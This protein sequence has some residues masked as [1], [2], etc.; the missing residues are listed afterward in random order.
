MKVKYSRSAPSDV[1]DQFTSLPVTVNRHHWCLTQENFTKYEDIS[2][3][4]CIHKHTMIGIRRNRE[5]SNI[6]TESN[7]SSCVQLWHG[8]V[9]DSSVRELWSRR[10]SVHF[11]SGS[12][13]L[14]VLC[15]SGRHPILLVKLPQ[16]IDFE[17]KLLQYHP[18][19][20]S[21][22]WTDQPGQQIL[23]SK[24]VRYKKHI[25]IKALNIKQNQQNPLHSICTSNQ[26]ISCTLWIITCM[27]G[28]SLLWP[29]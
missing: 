20:S 18:E 3:T 27:N 17:P 28:K 16:Q 13:G 5:N 24:E 19:K 26:R 11:H 25:V 12:K 14:S 10:S 6:L 4:S 29:P 1:I 8:C 23:H 21:Y 15:H 9:L 22:T 2:L 7:H